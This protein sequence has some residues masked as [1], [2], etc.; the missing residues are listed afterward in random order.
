MHVICNT[1]Q[2]DLFSRPFENKDVVSGWRN[3][4]SWP[5]SYVIVLTL[6]LIRY[7]LNMGTWCIDTVIFF[8]VSNCCASSPPKTIFVSWCNDT[9]IVHSVSFK[10]VIIVIT[11]QNMVPWCSDT[12]IFFNGGF[13]RLVVFIS[14]NILNQHVFSIWVG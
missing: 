4:M 8:V 10:Q 2:H 1:V 6:Q 14:M 3:F 13:K 9:L 11:Q 12:V 5:M 7:Q